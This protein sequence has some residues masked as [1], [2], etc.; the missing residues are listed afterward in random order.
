MA[1]R[2]KEP[3]AICERCGK[4][5]H[6]KPSAL[7]HTRYC[8]KECF[9]VAQFKGQ[10]LRCATCG[11]EIQVSPSLVRERNFCTNECRLA[12]LSNHV[13][14]EINV[15]GHT[16]GHKA[17]HLTTLNIERNPKLALEADA[18]IR[19]KY[20]DHRRIMEQHLGRKLEHW[21]DVHH[22]NGIH[23]DN[24]IENL[25]VI[26]HREHMKLHWRLAKERGVI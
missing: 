23:D 22:L 10:T 4:T 16:A 1:K 3:N 8:S 21:E 9:D 13:K 5:F 24:R 6:G 25:V 11:K 19:G 2:S 12:W 26:S 7:K 15:P 14:D 17:P 18:V 20:T